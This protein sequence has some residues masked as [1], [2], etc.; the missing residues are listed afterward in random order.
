MIGGTDADVFIY[1]VAA[2]AGDTINFF[3]VGLDKINLTQLM[4][5]LAIAEADRANRIQL[6]TI[7]TTGSLRLD[8]DGNGTFET[9]IA[10]FGD[11][12]QGPLR[13]TDII[14]AGS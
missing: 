12:L 7:G 13:T 8:A 5:D 11:I 3:Q 6:S 2:D 14:L 4:D 9:T 10:S 1:Q